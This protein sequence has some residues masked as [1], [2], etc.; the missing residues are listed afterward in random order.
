MN[1]LTTATV[2]AVMFFGAFNTLVPTQESNSSGI[3]VT[4]VGPTVDSEA[5]LA[6]TQT[7]FEQSSQPPQIVQLSEPVN[8]NQPIPEPAI[9]RTQAV[10]ITPPVQ[11]E[12][13]TTD[14]PV[15]V[16]A[17]SDNLLVA[18]LLNGPNES[19]FPVESASTGGFPTI[20]LAAAPRSSDFG[21]GTGSGGKSAS[22]N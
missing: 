14:T 21:G 1:N 12:S 11:A 20:T 18:T 10:V 16:G 6:N 2:S 17:E 4:N 13:Q 3:S 19:N 8:S 15:N 5:V 7:T 9:A 22:A